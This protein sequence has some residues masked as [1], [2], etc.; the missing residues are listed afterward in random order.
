MKQSILKSEFCKWQVLA[1]VFATMFYTG[2]NEFTKT[3]LAQSVQSFNEKSLP[4]QQAEGLVWTSLTYDMVLDQVV[5]KY[6]FDED[7]FDVEEMLPLF[8][9]NKNEMKN[10]IAPLIAEQGRK[11]KLNGS[12]V[13]I[14]YEFN[15]SK[16]S[17]DIIFSSEEIDQLI[18]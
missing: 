9:E 4:Q 14:K 2:C 11:M 8:Y 7:Y 6:T 13:K 10:Q 1:L 5:F 3:D 12:S 15:R 17:F 16:K 18:K